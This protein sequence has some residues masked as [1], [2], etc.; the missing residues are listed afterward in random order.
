MARERFVYLLDL[1]FEGPNLPPETDV[2]TQYKAFGKKLENWEKSR[3]EERS[4][5]S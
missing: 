4:R 3:G 5:R 1:W 2:G